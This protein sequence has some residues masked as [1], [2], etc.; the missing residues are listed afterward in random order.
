MGQEAGEKRK[1]LPRVKEYKGRKEGG[2]ERERG[3][4]GAREMEQV[5]QEGI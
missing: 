2:S 4:E 5:G 1:D 3:R